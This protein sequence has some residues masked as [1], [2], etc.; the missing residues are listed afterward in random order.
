MSHKVR[1]DIYFASLDQYQTMKNQLDAAGL[2]FN[3]FATYCLNLV[4]NQMLEEY[5]RQLDSQQE[6]AELLAEV[7]KELGDAVI[8]DELDG[9]I[10]SIS[11][12]EG[13]DIEEP[14]DGPA[15]NAAQG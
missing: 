5:K 3:R 10:E 8:G 11:D 4:W 12:A 2:P 9:N 14:Q 7:Q 13:V 15:D 6:D 1:A